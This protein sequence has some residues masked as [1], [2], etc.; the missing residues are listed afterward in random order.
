MASVVTGNFA[1]VQ[2]A[3]V[4]LGVRIQAAAP[5][6]ESSSARIVA[7]IAQAKAPRLTGYMASSVDAAGGI[8]VVGAPY[9]PAQEYGTRRHKAQPFLGPARDLGELPAFAAAEQILTVASR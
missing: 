4:A 3:L 5:A 8:V 6:M 1:Q 9:G 7:E 2:A